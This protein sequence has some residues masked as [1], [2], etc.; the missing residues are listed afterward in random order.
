MGNEGEHK[1]YM[2]SSVEQQSRQKEY[3]VGMF[4][5]GKKNTD[6][7]KGNIANITYLD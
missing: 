7:H 3:R 5:V 4:T 1:E 6:N 2:N